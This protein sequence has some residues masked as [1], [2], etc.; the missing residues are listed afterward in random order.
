MSPL[1]L[2]GP[3][4]NLSQ[5]W[6][7]FRGE[8][9]TG[10]AHPNSSPA[11]EVAAVAWEWRN[12]RSGHH[13]FAR[14][15]VQLRYVG[16]ERRSEDRAHAQHTP[17][18]FFLRSLHGALANCRGYIAGYRWVRSRCRSARIES[19]AVAP[20]ARRRGIGGIPLRRFLDEA[21]RRSSRRVTLEVTEAN[22]RARQFFATQRF[23]P[24]RRLAAYYGDRYDSLRLGRA[25]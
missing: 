12:T 2:L 8:Q 14:Q 24:V 16:E 22:E 23:K 9:D 13:F 1:H 20:A 6:C 25:L 11:F 3:A 4:R 5:G 18:H 15:C 17:Q 10:R 19:L 21:K 7:Q